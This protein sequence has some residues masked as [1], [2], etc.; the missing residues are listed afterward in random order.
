MSFALLAAAQAGV[1]RRAAK[2]AVLAQAKVTPHGLSIC[3]MN[4]HYP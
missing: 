2:M 1:D 3:A 4:T